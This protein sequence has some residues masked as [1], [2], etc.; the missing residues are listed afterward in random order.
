MLAYRALVNVTKEYCG[1]TKDAHR[2][3]TQI[4]RSKH[5]TAS[6]PSATTFPSSCTKRIGTWQHHLAVLA[7]KILRLHLAGCLEYVGEKLSIFEA[8]IPALTIKRNHGV[9]CIVEEY[10]IAG[11]ILVACY[12]DKRSSWAGIELGKQASL[13]DRLKDISKVATEESDRID[14]VH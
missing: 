3:T 4:S 12:G 13:P 10:C 9:C 11:T 5:K 2:L 14:A 7:L 1:M 6:S 8:N